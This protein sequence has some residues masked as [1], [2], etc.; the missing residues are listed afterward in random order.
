MHV[1]M[2]RV[3]TLNIWNRQEPWEARAR[4]IRRELEGLGADLVGLQE[5]L[6][7]EG[8]SDQAQQLAEGLGYR[9]TFG[10]AWEIGGG[11]SFGN[12]LLSRHPIV[13][14]RT[15]PLPHLDSGETRSLLY[16][17]VEHPAA[18]VPVFVTHLSWKLHHGHLRLR[19]V[20]AVCEAVF[21]L[22]PVG[23][24]YPPILMGDFNAVPDA[25]EIRYLKGLHVVDGKSV[26]FN[27]AWTYAGHLRSRQRL[28]P[29]QPRGEP[30]HRLRLRARPRQAGARP[31]H[32]GAAL[33]RRARGGRL[34]VR[35]L[36]RGLRPDDL[37]RAATAR[38]SRGRG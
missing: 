17:L 21:E 3:A 36:R 7:L 38:R 5:V 18:R 13:E 34:G 19:Q 11:L 14:T 4:L 1:S 28:H 33:L 35:S 6:R 29:T 32:R 12:A 8:T 10:A 30:T 23:R 15:I 22:A 16:A 26:F 20:V 2:L 9:T 31:A 25:D 37:S 24:T 27:D